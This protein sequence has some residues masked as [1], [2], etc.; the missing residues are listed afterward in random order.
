[1][2][3]YDSQKMYEIYD[4]WP[5][6]AKDSFSSNQKTVNFDDIEHIVF[7]GMGGSGA[8]GDVF[9]AVLSKSKIHVNVVK[10]YVLP[11]TVNS[12]TLVIAISVSGDTMETLSILKSA[13]AS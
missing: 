5:K 12:K 1:M 8:I 2:E 11:E 3:K 9:E 6:I 13:P 7:A 10:G 4:E